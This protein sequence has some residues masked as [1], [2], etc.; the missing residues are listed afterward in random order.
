MGA[1][2]LAW[3]SIPLILLS[4]FF[5]AYKINNTK[6]ITSFFLSCSLVSFMAIFFIQAYFSG[7]RTLMMISA[8]PVILFILLLSFGVYIF[9]AFLILNTRSILKKEKRDFKHFLTLI[10]AAALLLFVTVPRFIDLTAFPRTAAY[11][12]YSVYALIIYYLLHLTHFIVSMILCNFSPIQKDLRY[13]IVLGC[14]IKNGRVTPLLAGRIDR[15]IKLYNRQKGNPPKLLL[16]GGKGADEACSE[17]EAMKAYALERGIPEERLLTESASVSTL[18]NM[19]YSKEIM[20][21]DSGGEPYKCVYV[22]NNYHVL[23]AGVLARKAG[24][25][26]NG[27]GAGTAFYYLPNAVLREYIAHLYIHLKWNVAFS[28]CSLMFGSLIL[29]VLVEKAAEWLSAR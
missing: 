14:W 25:K 24:L 18:E 3:Y 22:T 15:A 4:V 2:F 7:S 11:L 26:I 29:P 6:L 5:A 27:A 8:V 13:I 10:L 17:A 12:S 1:E 9:I 21:C 20:D 16:S 19:K 23:R 28:L